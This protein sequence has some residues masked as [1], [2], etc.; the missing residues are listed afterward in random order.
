MLEGRGGKREGARGLMK[1]TNRWNHLFKQHPCRECRAIGRVKGAAAAS[2]D[3]LFGLMHLCEKGGGMESRGGA[4][5]FSSAQTG[6]F[7]VESLWRERRFRQTVR[8]DSR[9]F[10]MIAALMVNYS[11]LFRSFEVNSP[12]S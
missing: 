11:Q 1:V 6:S 9:G 10:D 7:R 5:R 3:S 2:G 8:R 12:Q 4:S